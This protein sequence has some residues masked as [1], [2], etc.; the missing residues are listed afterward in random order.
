MSGAPRIAVVGCGGMGQK[1]A[2]NAEQSGG[3]VVAGADIVEEAR[4]QFGSEFGADTFEDYEAMFDAVDP[5]GV[6]ITTPNAFHEPA[7]TAAFERD[8]DVL[9]EKPLADSAEAAERMAEAEAA[10]DAFGMV[11]FQRRFTPAGTVFKT[12]KEAGRFG[13]ITHVEG[14]YVRRRGIPGVDSWFTAKELAGGGCVIDIGVHEIDFIMYLLDFPSISEVAAQTRSEFGSR[15]DYSDPDDWGGKW[16]RPDTTFDVED[17]ASAFVRTDDDTTI[18]L[19]V[20][21]ATNRE[22]LRETAVRGTEAGAEVGGTTL[23]IVET[24]TE[25]VDHY[26]DVEVETGHEYDSQQ[27]KVATFVEGVE[28]GTAPGVST[29][30]EGLLTQRIIDAIYRSSERGEAIPFDY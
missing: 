13:E 2:R 20:A 25:G 16:G 28:T 18:S 23:D 27:R 21:W 14:N 29:L 3:E 10:S 6:S 5:D 9:V 30:E 19:E 22:P 12:Y 8:I 1:H 7:A 26:R 24:S 11:G 15:A 17:S 4:A